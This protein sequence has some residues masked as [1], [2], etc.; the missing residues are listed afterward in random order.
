MKNI[1][2]NL[3]IGFLVILLVGIISFAILFFILLFL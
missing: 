2:K 3:G 1:F